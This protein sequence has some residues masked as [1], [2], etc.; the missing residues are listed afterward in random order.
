MKLRKPLVELIDDE[1]TRESLTW[2]YEFLIN[3]P[4]LNGEFDFFEEEI[5]STA[6]DEKIVHKL[7]FVPKDVILTYKSNPAVDV[8]FQFDQFDLTNLVVQT[9]GP[10]VIRF[11]AGRYE[12][13]RMAI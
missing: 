2:I 6:T 8:M 12:W 9:S 4:L 10:V 13:R 11:L 1:N 7:G 3:V 5:R